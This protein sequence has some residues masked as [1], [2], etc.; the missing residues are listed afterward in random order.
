MIS[1]LKNWAEGIIIAVIIG[2]IIEMLVPDSNNKKYIKMVIGVYIMFSIISPIIMK[3]SDKEVSFAVDDYEG[4]YKKNDTYEELNKNFEEAS[5]YKIEEV[6]RQKLNEDIK[7][8]LEQKG[9]EVNYIYLDISTNDYNYGSVTKMDI[10]MSVK[11]DNEKEEKR[12]DNNKIKRV[13]GNEIN[14]G[15]TKKEEEKIKQQIP[16]ADKL[17][18]YL[19]EEYGVQTKDI[20]ING[21]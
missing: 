6:Y 3:F 8:K 5:E 7:E 15:S 21:K 20:L 4:Y 2:T 12:K 9:Y 11:Q 17:K 16:N 13:V 19:S 18:K 10:D 14:I 1:W